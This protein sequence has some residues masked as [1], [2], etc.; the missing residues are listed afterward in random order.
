MKHPRVSVE[1]QS[2]IRAAQ[3]AAGC[4]HA[5]ELLHLTALSG[6]AQL[7]LRKS[8]QYFAAVRAAP[9]HT[10]LQPAER[11]RPAGQR[12]G[13]DTEEEDTETE[14][15]SPAPRILSRRTGHFNTASV[16]LGGLLGVEEGGGGGGGVYSVPG[17][18]AS[19]CAADHRAVPCRAVSRH[20]ACFILHIELGAVV[21]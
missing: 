14:V 6:S 11:T 8:Q 2:Y 9:E 7:C 13:E 15:R 12:H 1:V 21:I 3:R 18:A 5:C 20:A 19:V 17:P 16:H 4:T 10:L